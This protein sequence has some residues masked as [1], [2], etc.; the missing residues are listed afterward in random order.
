MLLIGA[1][2]LLASFQRVLA[3][4]P[5]FDV[6]HVL[7]GI[8]SPPPA[9]YKEDR[10]AH[11]VLEPAARSRRARCPA[12]Q[13]AGITSNLPLSGDYSDSVI[14]AEGYVMT[15][16]ESLISPYRV[17]ISPGY[18]EAMKIPLKRG[19]LFT[20][21]DD[22]RAP[23]VVIVD[24][25]LA[26]R[27]WKDADPIGRRMWRPESAEELS[28][29]PGPK[30]H[31]YTVVGVVGNIRVDGPDGEGAGRRVLLSVRAG[32][33]PRHDARRRGRPA[34]PTIVTGGIRQ[35][36]TAIDPELPFFAVR[37]DAAARRG[38]A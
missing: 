18:F 33:R 26:K 10:A 17:S 23:K 25:R 22:E 6:D 31:F 8:V 21:S 27:F 5:G 36:V 12:S 35:Q 15:P 16:G 9:R 7:T 30:S 24:E 14:L 1:G 13:A 29:G 34:S 3:V 28:R 2:L 20:A 4:R 32:S 37:A 11:R 19:R 38:I